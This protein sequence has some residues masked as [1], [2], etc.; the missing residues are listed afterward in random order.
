[1]KRNLIFTVLF[2]LLFSLTGC[3][4]VFIW[5]LGDVL[6]L[7]IMGMI[8]LVFIYIYLALKV[9]EWRRKRKN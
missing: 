2:T 6:A 8:A 7:S 9:A 1:M 3:K 5:T 4:Q